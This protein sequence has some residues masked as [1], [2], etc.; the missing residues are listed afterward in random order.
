MKKEI[1]NNVIVKEE[2][3]EKAAKFLDMW[4][5]FWNPDAEE[6]SQEE[7]ISED[8][9]TSDEEKKALMK[10]L[11]IADNIMKPTAGEVKSHLARNIKIEAKESAQKALKE[12]PINIKI[13]KNIDDKEKE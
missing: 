10:A 11:K 9:N 13:E 3:R 12:K 8:E 2:N 1:E 5:R 7:E 4:K 6:L